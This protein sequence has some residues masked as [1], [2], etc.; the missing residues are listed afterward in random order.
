M[1]VAIIGSVGYPAKYGGFETIVQNYCELSKDKMDITVFC[2]KKHFDPD[3]RKSELNG[4]NLVYIPF[5][6]NGAQS[7]PYDLM[8]MIYALFFAD[9]LLVLGVSACIF[10]PFIKLISNKKIIVHIDGLEW[11][12]PKWKNWIKQFLKLSEKAA[13][14]YADAIISDNQGIVEHVKNIYNKDSELIE[15]GGDQH[16]KVPISLKWIKKHPFLNQQ[17]DFKVCRIEPENNIE[18]ILDA[19]AELPERNLVMVGNWEKS[20]FG[21]NLKKKS[22]IHGNLILLD[23]I[24]EPTELNVLRSNAHLYIHGHSAGGTNPS[25]VEAM[26]LGLPIFCYDV[27]YNRATT[28]NQALF[29]G[30]KNELKKLLLKTNEDKIAEIKQQLTEVANRRY[31][32]EVIAYKFSQLILRFDKNHVPTTLKEERAY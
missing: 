21:S 2:S 28:E 13:V 1:K 26:G 14:K 9:V 23:P 6:A 17:Y 3:E 10:L 18:M 11:R 16:Q 24:Y 30:S 8:S 25:L 5:D 19:Y 31:K 12:R 7:I 15:C 20:P 29:F 22:L 32:W 27:I 4:I